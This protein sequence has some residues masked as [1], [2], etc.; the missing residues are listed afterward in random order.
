[1]KTYI[2]KKAIYLWGANSEIITKALVDKL[3]K[4][5]G[6]KTYDKKYYDDKLK[7]GIGKIGADL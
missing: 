3:Y 7:E 2:R 6:S 1:M 5:F 4:I